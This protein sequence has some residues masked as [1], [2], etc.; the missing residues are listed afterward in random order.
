MPQ[1]PKPWFNNQTGWWTTDLGGRRI[2]L[3]RGRD[4]RKLA[5]QKFA[6]LLLECAVNPGP[7]VSP[8]DQTVPGV[9]DEYLDLCRTEET[10]RTWY[11]KRLIQERFARDHASRKVVEL[12]PYDLQK[13]IAGHPPWKS[14]DTKAKVCATVQALLNWATRSGLITKNPVVG[15]K[16]TG[17]NHRRPMTPREFRLLWGASRHGKK[18]GLW[19]SSRRRYRETLLMM[20]LTGARPAEIREMTWPD[21]DLHRGVI[22][23]RQHKTAGKTNEPRVIPLTDRLIRLLTSIG[24]RDGTVGAVFLTVHGRP[25]HRNSLA[26]KTM[27]L[28][29]ALGLPEDLSPYTLRHRFGTQGV[30]KGLDL[31]TLATVMGHSRVTTLEHYVHIAGDFDHLRSAAERVN[32]PFRQGSA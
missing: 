20:K 30:I 27:R 25:W 29:R 15:Y 22:V 18:N 5:K 21:I 17:G 2:K 11:E 26:L 12:R 7:D 28:R 9:V 14:R 1:E 19:V 32:S 8:E 13:W 4:Q 24:Q 6:S 16:V 31:K 10:E 3:A 23:L